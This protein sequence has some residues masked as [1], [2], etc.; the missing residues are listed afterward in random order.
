MILACASIVRRSAAWA[1]GVMQS[2]SSRITIL[3]A[4][5]V[6][7]RETEVLEK[8]RTLSRTTWRG[9]SAAARATPRAESCEDPHLDAALIGRVQ[10]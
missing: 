3:N 6:L 8:D 7:L 2:A 1:S 4:D 10:L 9:G 5:P